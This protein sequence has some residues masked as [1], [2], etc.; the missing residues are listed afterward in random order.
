MTPPEPASS[1]AP[2]ATPEAVVR[3]YWA[4]LEARDWDGVAALLD[5]GFRAHFP[6]SGETFD[7]AGWVRMNRAYPGDWHLRVVDLLVAAAPTPAEARVVT[8]VEVDLDGRTDRAL[9]F[10]RLR[11]GR[12][13]DLREHWPEPFPIP[14]W[15]LGP[16]Q[17]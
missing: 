6:Q 17:P 9:S 1:P 8:E 2:E 14:A 13:A 7:A 10:F 12:L 3:A 5:P 4:A 16:L 15:R 11:G